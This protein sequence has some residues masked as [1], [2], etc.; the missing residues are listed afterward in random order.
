MS[1]GDRDISNIADS[2]SVTAIFRCHLN[3]DDS[4]LQ[5]CSYKYDVLFQ[6][7]SFLG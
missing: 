6:V 7:I 4:Q 5:N 1:L 3:S 2:P